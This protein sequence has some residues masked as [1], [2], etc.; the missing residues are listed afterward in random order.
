MK[1][2]EHE[3]SEVLWPTGVLRKGAPMV[4][5][6]RPDCTEVGYVIQ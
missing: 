6:L 2:H 5:C 1:E 3:W 4:K